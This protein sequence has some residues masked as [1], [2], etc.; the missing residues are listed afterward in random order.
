M[1]KNEMRGACSIYGGEKRCI[2]CL[3]KKSE[4]RRPLGRQRCRW[5]DNIKMD[6]T[7]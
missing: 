6:L 4:E 5:E 2:Q 3:V 1:K 7:D